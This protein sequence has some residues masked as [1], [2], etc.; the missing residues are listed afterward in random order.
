M[1]VT[2]SRTFPAEIRGEI[3]SLVRAGFEEVEAGDVEAHVKARATKKRAYVALYHHRGD[4]EAVRTRFPRKRDAEAAAKRYGGPVEVH[5][6]AHPRAR[7]WSARSYDGVPSISRVTP[8]ARYLVTFNIPADPRRLT[9][10]P[11]THQ[12][13]RLKTSPVV[14]FHTWRE[15]LLHI[16]AHEARHIHQFRHGLSRS[17]LDAERWAASRL[18]RFRQQASLPARLP[19]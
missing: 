2:I 15:Q 6:W 7:G 12:D 18:E 13:P 16:A 10:Y 17:E 19:W 3:E 14:T 11:E 1:H 4:P 8:G 5:S 9:R